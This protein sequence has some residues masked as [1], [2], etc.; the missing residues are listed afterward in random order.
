[1]KKLM[2]LLLIVASAPAISLAQIKEYASTVTNVTVYMTGAE[3][4]SVAT[5]D[6]P[7]GKTTL[8]LNGLSPMLDPRSIQVNIDPGDITILSVSSRTNYLNGASDNRQ[9]QLLKDSVELINDKLILIAYQR[10]T[11]TKEKDLLFKNQSIGGTENGVKVDEIERSADFFRQRSNEINELLFQITKQERQLTETLERLNRQLQS[12][13]AQYNP[14]SSEIEITLMSPRAGSAKLNFSYMVYGCGWAP[15]YDIRVGGLD[16]PIQLIYRANLFNNSG[17]DWTDV[18]IKLSTAD[19][20][21][22]AQKPTLDKWALNYTYDMESNELLNVV[23]A[24][25]RAEVT[26]EEEGQ[27]PAGYVNLEVAELASEFEILIPYTIL[28]DSKAYT[29][30]VGSY[31]LPAKFESYCA[32]KID[33]DAFLVARITEWNQL[34]LV[35]GNVSVYFN[36]T[37]IGQSIINTATVADTMSISLGRDQKIMVKRTQ[38]M[39]DSKS[40]VVGNSIKETFMYEMLIRNNRESSVTITIQDQVPV[41]Q[42]S[43]IS[44]DVI[45]ISGGL[46]DPLSGIVTW[47]ITLAPGETKQLLLS[48]SIKYPKNQQINKRQFR[49]VSSPKF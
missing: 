49:S 39:E 42:N 7:K 10:E 30:D 16:K 9:I 19:P 48:Y 37:F 3:L 4:R 12:L 47:K 33:R 22:G 31:E 34:N 27:G 38:R 21:K 25:Q 32:P 8:I 35:T 17:V 41:S 20:G 18:M 43:D 45:N 13:N 24:E 5:I 15:K 40:Q 23:N 46:L 11:Y 26:K 29:V 6:V 1:M 2:I 44:V 28:S 14:P 36:G